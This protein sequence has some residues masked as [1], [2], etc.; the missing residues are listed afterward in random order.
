[1]KR[2]KCSTTYVTHA[3]SNKVIVGVGKLKTFLPNVFSFRHA[4]YTSLNTYFSIFG[5]NLWTWTKENFVRHF[6]PEVL[7]FNGSSYVRGFEV[8]QLPGAGTF[9]FNLTAKF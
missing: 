9:G 7:T 4:P 3:S 2:N 6:D 5:R 1:M 8:G